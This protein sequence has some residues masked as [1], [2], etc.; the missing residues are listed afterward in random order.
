MNLK[1]KIFFYIKR[2]GI[3]ISTAF[4]HVFYFGDKNIHIDVVHMMW[5][6]GIIGELTLT[7]RQARSAFE[8]FFIVRVTENL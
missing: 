6:C 8:V 4:Y 1:S 3:N 5:A 7:P 2:E